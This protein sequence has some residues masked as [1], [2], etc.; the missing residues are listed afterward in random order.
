M[1]RI[2]KCNIITH[3]TLQVPVA[4]DS[5]PLLQSLLCLHSR[6]RYCSTVIVLISNNK[7]YQYWNRNLLNTSPY[8]VISSLFCHQCYTV[9]PEKKRTLHTCTYVNFIL[10]WITSNDIK[11]CYTQDSYIYSLNNHSQKCDPVQ[12]RDGPTRLKSE[13]AVR[14]SARQG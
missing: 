3:G 1:Q 9:L 14:H 2:S 13:A 5:G 8:T 10:L 12:K 6:L 4:S 7:R 11:L